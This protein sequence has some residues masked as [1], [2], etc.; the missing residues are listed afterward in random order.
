MKISR[1][2]I[3]LD[4]DNPYWKEFVFLKGYIMQSLGSPI[5]RVELTERMLHQAIHDAIHQYMKYDERTNEFSI[6]IVNTANNIAEIPPGI[7]ASLIRDVLFEET[8]NIFGFFTPLDEGIVASFPL[9]SILDFSGGFFDLSQ[10]YMA[11]QNLETAND[12]LGRTRGWEIINGKINVFPS[13][14]DSSRIAIV[15]G[16]VL[17]P[18]KFEEDEWVRSY[19]VA[20]AKVMLGN[21][22]RKLSGFTA[23]GGAATTDGGDL[24]GEGKTEMAE[25]IESLKMGRPSLPFLQF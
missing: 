21:I 7:D 8:T 14:K 15:Y 9:R 23:A 2:N 10:Y 5:V 13:M 19:S 3:P 4:Y 24:I 11:R 20:S 12:I 6:E 1:I 17:D 18:Q 16:K 25:L 22:R